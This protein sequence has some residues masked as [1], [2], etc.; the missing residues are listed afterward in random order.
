[1]SDLLRRDIDTR[2]MNLGCDQVCYLRIAL[3]GHAGKSTGH[4]AKSWYQGFGHELIAGL[5]RVP[6]GNNEPS[7]FGR[8]SDVVRL[9]NRK[10]ALGMCC[11]KDHLVLIG[12]AA[13]EE[14]S[15]EICH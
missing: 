7:A 5:F 11:L 4:L 2:S 13:F 12:S 1:M 8:S 15:N 10:F 6:Y 14:V 3:L 9:A